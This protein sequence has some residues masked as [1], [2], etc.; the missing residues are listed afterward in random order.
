MVLGL[1][2]MEAVGDGGGGGGGGGAVFL[3]Q[4]PS[5][6]T[7]PR[8]ATSAIHFMRCCFTVILPETPNSCSRSDEAFYLKL[9]LGWVLRPVKVN[10]RTLVPSASIIQISSFPVRLD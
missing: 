6:I 2:D 5:I 8:A 1:T 4:A 10:W 9:Q 3:W 7:A